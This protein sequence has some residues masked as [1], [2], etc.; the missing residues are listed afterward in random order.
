MTQETQNWTDITDCI[1]VLILY[2]SSDNY[3]FA[4]M[5][6]GIL[7]IENDNNVPEAVCS[8]YEVPLNQ[9]YTYNRGCMN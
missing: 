1:E 5:L 7:C 6:H 8:S 9:R 3:E 4:E 2:W